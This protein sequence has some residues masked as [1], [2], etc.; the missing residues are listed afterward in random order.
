MVLTK[1]V[2]EKIGYSKFPEEDT[3]EIT[4]AILRVYS[5][6]GIHF[7][8]D[9]DNPNSKVVSFGNNCTVA[10]SNS[11]NEASKLLTGDIFTDEDE[12]SFISKKK[13]SPP[14]VVLYFKESESR[15]LHGGYRQEIDGNIYLYDGFP[16]GKPEI[17]KW[18]NELLPNIVTSMAVHFSTPERLAVMTPVLRSVFGTTTSGKTVFD[19]KMTSGI[20]TISVSNCHKIDEINS[21]LESSSSFYS[22]LAAN[23]TKHLY[24]AFNEK[25]KLK[26]FLNYFL[27]IERFTHKQYKVLSGDIDFNGIVNLPEHLKLSGASFFKNQV[28]IAKNLSQRFHWCALMHWENIDDSDISFFIKAKKL[29]D[30][31]SHGENFDEATLPV[32]KLKELSLKLLKNNGT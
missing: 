18:E 26:Q 7:E 28:N 2:I 1:Y 31:I 30:R 24:T 23:S 32:A 15:T 21:F 10:I 5:L 14:F 27:F 12:E 8:E 22:M 11:I 16:N 4:F 19:L 17:R 25:D 29:R 20:G 13:I 9:C 6:K 3:L